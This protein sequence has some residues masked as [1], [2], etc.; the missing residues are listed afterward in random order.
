MRP[1]PPK[2]PRPARG[3]R[4]MTYIAGFHLEFPFWPRKRNHSTPVWPFRDTVKRFFIGS[5]PDGLPAA[6]ASPKLPHLWPTF[7]TPLLTQPGYKR[8]PLLTGPRSTYPVGIGS[9]AIRP[10]I[11]PNRRRVRCPSASSSQE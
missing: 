4:S 7:A 5:T 9:S 8:I 11:A 6:A 10:S 1:R 2:R 3:D